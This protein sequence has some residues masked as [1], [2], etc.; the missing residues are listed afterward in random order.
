M[1]G[2]DRF[3][4][5]PFQRVQ[6]H[7]IL[8]LVLIF[9]VG[10]PS[11][12]SSAQ[13]VFN[14]S[15][16]NIKE[17]DFLEEQEEI[18]EQNCLQVSSKDKNLKPSIDISKPIRHGE[19]NVKKVALTFDDGPY[20]LTDEYIKVLREYDVPATFFLLGMQ[21]D[22]YP[23]K[24]QSI[25]DVGFEIGIHSYA[26]KQL[27]KMTTDSLNADLAESLSSLKAATG[28]DTNLFRP[29]YGDFSETVVETAQKY[30]LATILWN[31]DPRDWQKNSAEAIANHVLEY[32]QDGS[33]ILLH[34]GREGTLKA[35]PKIIDGLREKGYEI[36]S[37]SELLSSQ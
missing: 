21:I 29:P 3:V 37:I 14:P 15:D 30:D 31:V 27:T 2:L 16:F 19:Q 5:N 11:K 8:V 36:V 26:H 25:A 28:I 17:Q 35:L 20:A 33:I 22:K 10:F 9:S 34:E 4:K 24:A 7:L 13:A 1:T 32:T 6:F 18:C 23:D 12:S